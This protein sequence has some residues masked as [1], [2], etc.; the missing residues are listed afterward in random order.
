[1]TSEEAVVCLTPAYPEDL[2]ECP[3]SS[4]QLDLNEV[5]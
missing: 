4:L 2:P 5:S 1:M 3:D